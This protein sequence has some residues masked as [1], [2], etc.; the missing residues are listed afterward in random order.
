[1]YREYFSVNFKGFQ[2]ST[3]STESAAEESKRKRTV[4][5][6]HERIK[7]VDYL[8]GLAEPI[9]ADSNNAIAAIV[10][11]ATKVAI[12]YSQLRYIIDELSEM[13]LGSKVHV[14]SLLSIDD[15]MQ[16]AYE[17]SLVIEA[18]I[19]NVVSHSAEVLRQTLERLNT[20]EQ[21]VASLTRQM[22]LEDGQH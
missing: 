14:K 10:S 17:R 21:A 8:R 4:L 22:D 12:N 18:K 5:S 19:D 11:E 20:L 9:V 13:N 2:M 16:A 1:M 3:E 7:V 15:Q 6:L